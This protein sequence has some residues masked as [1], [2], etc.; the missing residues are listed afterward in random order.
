MIE[1][2]LL[3]SMINSQ[4]VFT[5]ASPN[6][7]PEMFLTPGNKII[8]EAMLE[9]FTSDRILVSQLLEKN[10]QLNTIGGFGR[11]DELRGFIEVPEK[12]VV[13]RW[14]KTLKQEYIAFSIQKAGEII[15][16]I[17]AS[18]YSTT[19]VNQASSALLEAIDLGSL[20]ISTL[21]Q[22]LE[23][24]LDRIESGN[25]INGLY[26]R[27]LTIGRLAGPYV[28]GDVVCLAGGAGVGKTFWILKDAIHQVKY[29]DAWCLFI[30]LEMTSEALARRVL[31]QQFG[32]HPDAIRD[33]DV[34]QVDIDSVREFGEVEKFKKFFIARDINKPAEIES[35]ARWI[36][37]QGAQKLIIVI[38]PA[39]LAEPNNPKGNS[40][41]DARA[42]WNEAKQMTKRLAD[43]IEVCVTLI[44]HHITK[45]ASRNREE[46]RPSLEDLDTA[47]H[48][49]IS[50]GIIVRREGQDLVKAYC[51][52]H[53][54]GM[55]DWDAPMIWVPRTLSFEDVT[56]FCPTCAVQGMTQEM[57]W[58]G[59]QW[60][61]PVHS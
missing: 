54:H 53:R 44:A 18:G 45:E 16:R 61:C 36:I 37:A 6:I 24:E 60:K 33:A 31:S 3:S 21:D 35:V 28:S 39:I 29:N 14:I 27:S 40:T 42:F 59:K 50:L 23:I 26:P 10:G 57:N 51:V 8:Y 32:I 13:E 30:P 19:L 7:K 22:D 4:E 34:N 46:K 5:Y 9:L 2:A 47:G 11:L 43:E 17:A 49:N 52:K 15:S 25:P 41:T 55:S 56:E 20:G 38:D 48:H 1:D 58:D 12:Q